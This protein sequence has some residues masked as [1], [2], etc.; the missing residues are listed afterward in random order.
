MV[1]LVSYRRRKSN[2]EWYESDFREV[3]I[4]FCERCLKHMEDCHCPTPSSACGPW[5]QHA[6]SDLAEHNYARTKEDQEHS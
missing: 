3:G 2:G 1:K 5:N 4:A 6:P